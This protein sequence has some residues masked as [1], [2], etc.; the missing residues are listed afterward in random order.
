MSIGEGN[1]I[2][3]GEVLT[4]KSMGLQSPREYSLHPQLLSNFLILRTG[5]FVSRRYN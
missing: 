5:G 2:A 1:A 3:F 4:G